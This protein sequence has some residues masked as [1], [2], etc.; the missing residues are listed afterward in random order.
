VVVAVDLLSGQE[1]PVEVNSFPDVLMRAISLPERESIRDR[2][3]ATADLVIAPL[4]PP[5]TSLDRAAIERHIRLGEEAT[6]ARIPEFHR[7]LE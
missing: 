5:L 4:L 7:L 3:A 6:R 2:L 1:Q